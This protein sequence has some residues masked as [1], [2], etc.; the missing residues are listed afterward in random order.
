MSKWGCR[1]ICSKIVTILLQYTIHPETIFMRKFITPIQT[2]S[3]SV[4]VSRCRFTELGRCAV[5]SGRRDA[6]YT[7]SLSQR[8]QHLDLRLNW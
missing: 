4:V 8:S 6:S 7:I 1:H 3:G 5:E 2:I